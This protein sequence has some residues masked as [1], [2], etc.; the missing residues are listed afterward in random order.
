MVSLAD[1]LPTLAAL[2]GKPLDAS[3]AGPQDGVNIL[4]AFFGDPP[5]PLRRDMILHSAAGVF[6]IRR[7]PWKWIEGVPAAGGP[8]APPDQRRPQLYHLAEDP[9]ETRDVA[10]DHPDVARELAALLRAR[11]GAETAQ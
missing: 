6:A 7:G 5:E 3:E 10:A 2:T 8:R 4:P 9:A 1:V 11:R